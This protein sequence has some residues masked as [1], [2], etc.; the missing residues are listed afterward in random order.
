LEPMYNAK[1]YK[2]WDQN[3]ELMFQQDVTWDDVRWLKQNFPQL[4]LIVKGIMTGDD[5]ILAVEAGADGIMVSNHG[6]RQLDGCLGAIDAL[7][8]VV[9]AVKGR[10]VPVFMDGGV[11]RGTDI[12][13]ALAIGASAVGIG[14]PIF[15]AL[16]VGG[17]AAVSNMLNLFQRELETAMALTGCESV[18]DITPAIVARHPDIACSFD[19]PHARL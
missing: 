9:A 4:P 3:S 8:E 5:A 10:G 13:K 16:T 12:L 15:F 14:K 11:R 7:P 2:S 6:G 17:Q 18:S 1:K 19:Q